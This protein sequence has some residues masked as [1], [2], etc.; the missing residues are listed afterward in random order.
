MLLPI[1]FVILL[2]LGKGQAFF[3]VPSANNSLGNASVNVS[4]FFFQLNSNYSYPNYRYCMLTVDA[5]FING[6]HFTWWEYMGWSYIN[7]ARQWL[8]K[9]N[10][11]GFSANTPIGYGYCSPWP[12]Q[13]GVNLT[14]YVC[15]CNTNGCNVNTSTCETSV[16]AIRQQG[17]APAQPSAIAPP[18][19]SSLS[20]A[21]GSL[22]TTFSYCNGYNYSLDFNA[23]ACR[24]YYASQTVM[25]GASYLF[26]FSWSYALSIREADRYLDG[27]FPLVGT[28]G[29][30]GNNSVLFFETN[31]STLVVLS[32]LNTRYCVCYCITNMCNLNISTCTA[33][34]N[35]DCTYVAVNSSATNTTINPTSVSTSKRRVKD[36]HLPEV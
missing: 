18:L 35:F 17:A 12:Y 33:G 6:T 30:S 9:R 21:D 7:P 28:N 23:S 15:I 31:T 24:D 25:C 5:D 8:S 32:F 13:T 22:P 26:G 4:C 34:I 1:L 29:S 10:C 36:S 2:T 19:N 16:D 14:S 20:C 3:L 11:S 27:W